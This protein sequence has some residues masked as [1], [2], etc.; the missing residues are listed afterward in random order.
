MDIVRYFLALA[1]IIAHTNELAGFD[2]RFPISSFEA[3]GG[4]FALSGFLMYPNY[5]R[6]NNFRKYTAQRARRILP[7]YF[8][9]VIATAL[10]LGFASVLSL[11]SYYSSGGFWSYLAANLSFLNWLS[12]SLPGVFSGPEYILPAVNGSLWT[13][14][15]EWCLY[16]SVPI[17][18]FILS[19]FKRLK[20]YWLACLTIALSIGY[21]ILFYKLYEITGKTIFSILGRQIFGQLSYFYCGMLIYFNRDFFRKNIYL[22]FA[23]G[24]GLGYLSTFGDYF[25]MILNPVAISITVLAFSLFP[26]DL[27]FLRHKNNVSYEMYLFHFPIVQLSIYWG[28]NRSGSAVEFTYVLASTLL[29][30]IIVHW[31]IEKLRR[32]RKFIGGTLP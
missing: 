1:V 19:R 28:V 5:R 18:V 27:K 4:F 32:P 24:L 30:S 29:L 31:V 13:M 11:P 3:V 26:Y 7:P 17:F 8:F 22:M 15:V 23:F 16:F 12:P 21:V 9:I 2:V 25:G 20:H 6:H 10:L 14:K